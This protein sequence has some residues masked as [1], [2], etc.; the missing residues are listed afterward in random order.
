MKR[1]DLA[2][3]ISIDRPYCLEDVFHSML[4]AG[5]TVTTTIS[6]ISFDRS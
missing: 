6:S 3:V 5:Q 1:R 4:P 2:T